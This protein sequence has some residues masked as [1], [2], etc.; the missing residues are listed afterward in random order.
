MKRFLLTAAIAVASFTATAVASDVGVSISI[1]QPGFYGQLNIGDYPQPS[2]IYSQPIIVDRAAP[3]N[4]EPIYLHVPQRHYLHWN[5]YCHKYNACNQRVYFVHDDW[6]E[7]EYVPRYQEK[8]HD[9]ANVH[10]DDRRD[11][12]KDERRNERQEDHHGNDHSGK[13]HGDDR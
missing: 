6:Y 11:D 10:R 13:N 3:M 4:Q 7:H 9:H 12:R 8:H 2:V 1:G 5:K